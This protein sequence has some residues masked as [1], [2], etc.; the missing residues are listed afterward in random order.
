MSVL[1]RNPVVVRVSAGVLLVVCAVSSVRQKPVPVSLMKATGKDLQPIQAKHSWQH[2][3]PRVNEACPQTGKSTRVHLH[4]CTQTH[5]QIRSC[6]ASGLSLLCQTWDSPLSIFTVF[7]Q[8]APGKLSS[9]APYMPS[10]CLISL[11]L[12]LPILQP[13]LISPSPPY[14]THLLY[15]A[16]CRRQL[17][18]VPLFLSTPFHSGGQKG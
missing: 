12:P 16:V 5:T 2:W 6:V 7:N 9:S 1:S 14:L 10:S 11:Q 3:G 17:G 4:L 13:A 18:H 8:C 15:L